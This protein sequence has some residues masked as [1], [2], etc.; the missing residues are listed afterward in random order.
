MTITGIETTRDWFRSL[1]K[2]KLQKIKVTTYTNG[3]ENTKK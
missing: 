2:S 3:K 1:S